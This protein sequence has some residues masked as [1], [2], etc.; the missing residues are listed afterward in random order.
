MRAYDGMSPKVRHA[1]EELYTYRRRH[2]QATLD[3]VREAV[4]NFLEVRGMRKV[5]FTLTESVEEHLCIVTVRLSTSWRRW[6]CLGIWHWHIR[7]KL[8][9]ALRENTMVGVRYVVEFRTV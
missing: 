7:R 5:P 3:S 8:L 6:L 2:V 4:L 9:Q 1:V